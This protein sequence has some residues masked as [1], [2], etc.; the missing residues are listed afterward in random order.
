MVN[1]TFLGS[2]R[3]VVSSSVK[4]ETGER[5]EHGIRFMRFSQKYRVEDVIVG[6]SQ[7]R[8]QVISQGGLTGEFLPPF[9]AL[10]TRTFFPCWP[11]LGYEPGG[12]YSKSLII[13]KQS[14]FV[15]FQNCRYHWFQIRAILRPKSLARGNGNNIGFSINIIISFRIRW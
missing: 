2:V 7:T 4:M 8:S 10:S 11:L 12:S 1:E 6:G 9:F 3:L 15:W 14:W 5:N 13:W